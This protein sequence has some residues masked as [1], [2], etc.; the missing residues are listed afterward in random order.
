MCS[1]RM[2]YI[3]YWCMI[4]NDDQTSHLSPIN[5]KYLSNLQLIYE[6][7]QPACKFKDL[8]TVGTK[9]H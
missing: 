9:Q 3:Q 6:S 8:H 5:V 7:Q 2:I 4:E 1:D